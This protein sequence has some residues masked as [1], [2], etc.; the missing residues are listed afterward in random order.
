MMWVLSIFCFVVFLWLAAINLT[1]LI[2][3]YRRKRRGSLVPFLGGL[4]GAFALYAA[5][6]GGFGKLWF[7]PLLLDV[8]CVPLVLKILLYFVYPKSG[9]W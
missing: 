9:K 2:Q 6:G 1:Q 3:V 8:G 4:C 7:L 5:P